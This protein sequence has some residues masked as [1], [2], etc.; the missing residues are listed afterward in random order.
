MADLAQINRIRQGQGLKPYNETQY[1]NVQA[2]KYTDAELAEYAHNGIGAVAR[3]GGAIATSAPNNNLVG[4]V[5]Q[6]QAQP[7]QQPTQAQP[8]QAV[9]INQTSGLPA[10]QTFKY[11]MSHSQQNKFVRGNETYKARGQKQL[12]EL[13]FR[14]KICMDTSVVGAQKQAQ[15]SQYHL[16]RCDLISHFSFGG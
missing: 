6:T 5:A 2:G 11:A 10:G 1:A 8:V 7:T 12:T 9:V 13:E 14:Q 16:S 3:D 15:R 4:P